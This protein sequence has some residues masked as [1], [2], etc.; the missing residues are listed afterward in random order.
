MPSL[1]NYSETNTAWWEQIGLRQSVVLP[2]SRHEVLVQKA[3]AD[4][5]Q[6]HSPIAF[7]APDGI[8]KLTVKQLA[9][10]IDRVAKHAEVEAQSEYERAELERRDFGWKMIEE[11]STLS[12]A[13]QIIETGRWV[14]FTRGE[15]IAWCWNLFQ[16]EPQGFVHPGS[17]VRHRAIQELQSGGIPEVFGYPERARALAD[18]GLTPK[19]YREHKEA[20]GERTFTP[21]DVKH[22]R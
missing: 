5:L 1:K 12:D 2:P 22:S 6:T 17:E 20:L 21:L 7:L 3:I 19:Q 18:Q 11:A 9:E 14:A 16:Y 10:L 4:V 8:T 13:N 15:A